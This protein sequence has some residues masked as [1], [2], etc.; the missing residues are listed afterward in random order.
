[1]SYSFDTPFPSG[2]FVKDYLDYAADRTDASHAYHEAAGLALLALATPNVR[3]HLAPYPQGL[4]ANLYLLI[5]G[6]S[7]R[8]RKS[9]AISLAAD[10]GGAAIPGCR[11]P[12]AFSPEAFAETLAARPK[13]STLWA[14]DEFG[15]TLLKLRSSKYMAGLTGLLL[16]LYA[17]NNYEVRRHSKR[18]KGG[19]SEEDTDRIEQPNLSILG[20]TTPAVFE[21]L[22]EADVLSG[23]L[24]RFAVIN[25]ATKPPRKP[26]FAIPEG[27]ETRRN[28][29]VTRLRAIYSAAKER[30]HTVQ[31]QSGALEV[32]DAFAET[33]EESK[34]V[35]ESAKTMQQRLSAM[36]VKVA[37]LSAAGWTEGVTANAPLRVAIQ[38]AEF[39]VTVVQRWAAD[40][41]AFAERVGATQFETKLA[42]C[43][44]L[45]QENQAIPRNDIARAVHCPKRLMDEIEETLLDRELIKLSTQKTDHGPDKLL[46]VLPTAHLPD[47]EATPGRSHLKVV[48]PQERSFP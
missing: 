4:P 44:W 48:S 9:T 47:D 14:P 27:I 23:L 19:G 36:A 39:A 31:F 13:D 43:L 40:A 37:M 17:G 41:K 16:T 29:L 6:D 8:S 1:M 11:I 35:N 20:A 38:D 26:F 33:L 32:L 30:P 15:E 34:E 5:V 10:I 12:D 24:P 18:V 25:P 22:T 45:V 7:T 2:H 46:W 42:K 28:Q 21:T 3:A